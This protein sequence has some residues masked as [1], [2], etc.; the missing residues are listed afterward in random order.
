MA[1]LLIGL[2]LLQGGAFSFQQ[3]LW[4]DESTQLSGLSLSP[5]ELYRWLSGLLDNPFH[6]PSDR[7][8]VL[9]YLLGGVW[10]SIFGLDILQM[11]WLSLFL[12]IVSLCSLAIYLSRRNMPLVLLGALGFLCLSPNLTVIAVEI[13]SYALFFCLSVFALILLLEVIARAER[14]ESRFSLF[15]VLAVILVLAINTHFF[16]VLLSGSIVVTYAFLAVFDRRFMVSLRLLIIVGFILLLGVVAI[17]PQVLASFSLSEEKVVASTSI[18]KAAVKLIYRLVAHQ[19]MVEWF[20]APILSLLCVYGI[21]AFSFF[22]KPSLLKIALVL[23]LSVGCVTAFVASFFVP[24]FDALAPHY[25]IWMLPFLA[26]LLGI[27]LADVGEGEGFERVYWPIKYVLIT[28]P[29]VLLAVGQYY[30]AIS[31]E[32]YAHTR[33]NRV[34]DVVAEYSK[35]RVAIVY[36]QSMAKTWFAG[37]YYFDSSIGQ[38]IATNEGYVDLRTDKAAQLST[39]E[40]LHEVLIVAYG[41]DVFSRELAAGDVVYALHDTSPVY[42]Q[43]ELSPVSWGIDKASGYLAQESA[44]IVVY[45]KSP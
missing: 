26:V 33:F 42:Q 43:V 4:V 44:E 41:K 13:R 38:Y 2:F 39:I 20:F 9:S 24:G 11:R 6:V 15:V 23:V 3:S 19:S 27:C 12:V 5:S 40:S 7:M 36:N 28:S 45:K 1:V 35:A 37:L 32:K 34:I 25:N 29:F 31:G 16:G 17:L 30:L 14:G 22:N 8:P 10:A 21:I 18:F